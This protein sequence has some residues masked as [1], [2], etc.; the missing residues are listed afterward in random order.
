[1]ETLEIQN[2][3]ES[4]RGRMFSHDRVEETK[5]EWLTPPDLLAKLGHFD[6]D[7]CA[8]VPERR[9]WPTA[10]EHY[11]ITQ[12]GLIRPWF[13]RVWCNPP[14]ENA[15]ARA[16]LA[17]CAEHGNAVVLIFARVET[18]NWFD[19]IWNRADA[20]LFVRGRLS[21]YHASGKAAD[22]SAGAPSAL[23]AYGLDNVAALRSSGIAGQLV[24]LPNIVHE[25]HRGS[26]SPTE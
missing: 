3:T 18:A 7:P 9:P 26:P 21:F 8:P 17:R 5:H 13:G 1:M 10:A 25:P 4:K 15:L 12:N 16:F 11:D 22:C 14:Y 19:H 24:V 20:V 23:I 6:L 2:Q